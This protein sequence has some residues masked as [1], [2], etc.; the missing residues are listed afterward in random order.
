MLVALP[1]SEAVGVPLSDC[2]IDADAVPETVTLL[3]VDTEGV[4]EPVSDKVAETD[5]VMVSD[6][7]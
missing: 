2:D 5:I 4:G 6:M 7:V 1:V 3:L